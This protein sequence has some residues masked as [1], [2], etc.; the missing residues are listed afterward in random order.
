MRNRLLRG[1]ALAS[2]LALALAACGGDDGE[3]GEATTTAAGGADTT[4]A[5]EI[6][7]GGTL[8]VGAE[9]EPDCAD[10]IASCAGSSWGS[11]MMKVQTIPQVFDTVKEGEDWVP[12]ASNLLQG[13]P[14]LEVGPPQKVTYKINP[15]A[16]WD[17]GTP[18]TGKDF[19]YTALQIRDGEDIYD[20]TGYDKID[21][22]EA[23]D[24]ATVVVTFTEPY[25]AWKTLFGGNYGVLPSHLL[26]GK[27]RAAIMKDGYSFSGGP[28]KI[29][30][31]DKGVSITL[32]PNP[33]YWGEK[34]KLDKVIFQFVG[35]TAATFAAFKAGQ[36]QMIYPQ[37][38]LDAVEQIQAGLS[39]VKSQ[40]SAVTPNVEAF[41]INNAKPP[42][43]S[44]AVRQAFAY[45]IDRDAIVKRLFGALGVEKAANSF[46]PPI[47]SAFA[48]VNAFAGYKLDLA[49]VDELMT[50]DGWAKGA[51][52][53]WAKGGQRASFVMRT[54]AGN[55]RRELTQQV[56]QEQLKAAGF[57]MTIE[58]QKAGDLFGKSLP[59]GDYQVAIYAQ[60][61]TFVDPSLSSLFLST[62]IPS[63]ANNN[64]GQ[65]WTRTNIPAADPLLK[66]VDTELDPAKRK[67]ASID[68]EA[69]LAEEATSLPFN[70]LPN[71]LLYSEKVVGPVGGD[72]VNGPFA[73]LNQVGL[74]A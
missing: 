30:K 66:A 16:K 54:T 22:I 28:W 47:L 3:S 11:W 56:V 60:V 8:I 68:V 72:V 46:N 52:G 43:D 10:W 32:V 27:D 20:K 64:S 29:E 18:I 69:L 7:T 1:I 12:K 55:K 9:Q 39:G 25:A 31:W 51:D 73:N 70:P 24:D 53:I 35:D 49:K 2:G 26:E 74:A 48:N 4:A 58:N 19:V 44:K 40:I 33:G 50:G 57:E 6:P 15:A 37:P 41:W 36:V 45:A 21:T 23:P 38:Q 63:E 34:P 59:A 42:F 61:A 65:N 62:N 67:Q 17:D 13:E 14:T 71:I 5:A